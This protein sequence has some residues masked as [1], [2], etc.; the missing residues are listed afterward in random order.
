MK[1]LS[2]GITLA[3][4]AFLVGCTPDKITVTIPSSIVEK[5]KAGNLA[6]V[7]V[8]A[9]YSSTGKDTEGNLPKVKRVAMR[10]LGEGAEIDLDNADFNSRLTASFKIPFGKSAALAD[11]PKSILVLTLD[12]SGK[13]ELKDGLGLK[14]LNYDLDDIDSSI[15]AEFN[16]GETLFRF[17]GNSNSAL[18]IQVIGAFANDKAIAIGDVH[19]DEDDEINVKF[20]RD[21]ESIWHSLSPF[22]NLR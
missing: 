10:H 22:V 21:D 2:L 1:K 14:A 6:Y 19:V 3:A 4:V 18:R 11:A 5:V 12:D 16:G 17:T 8:R 20:N 15:K 7:K 13:I 9:V